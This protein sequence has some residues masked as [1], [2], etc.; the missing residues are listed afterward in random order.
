MQNSS[1]TNSDNYSSIFRDTNLKNSDFQFSRLSNVEFSNT[2]LDGVSLLDV[3]P[4]DS[5]FNDVEFNDTKINTCL[6]HD[7][8][9]RIL[10]KILRNIDNL[11]LEVFENL[12]IGICNN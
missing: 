11:G 9:S 10:N 1:F 6:N 4:I 3:Y 5:I 7:M 12:I 8:L 2:N